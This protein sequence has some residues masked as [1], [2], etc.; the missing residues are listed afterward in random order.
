MACYSILHYFCSFAPSTKNAQISLVNTSSS[1]KAQLKHNLS[2]KHFLLLPSTPRG[3]LSL[4]LPP[5]C[6]PSPVCPSSSEHTIPPQCVPSPVCPSSSEHT[7]ARPCTGWSL[8]LHGEETLQ[9][10]P[11]GKQMSPRT[12]G[13]A[14][15]L[16]T[17]PTPPIFSIRQIKDQNSP[18]SK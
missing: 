2:R 6:V 12:S 11:N 7:T 14:S 5:Q 9:N 17:F 18:E 16:S 1:F 4:F 3:P 13:Y 8:G 10:E 15:L